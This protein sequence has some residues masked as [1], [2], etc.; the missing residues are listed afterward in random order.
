MKNDILNSKAG[1]ALDKANGKI[2]GVCA[3][4]GNYFNVDPLWVRVGT[5]VTV[6]A[7]FGLAIPVYFAI[8]IL[9]D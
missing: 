4:I 9:A 2:M 6:L 8:G 3:G 7:G 5:V 1:F